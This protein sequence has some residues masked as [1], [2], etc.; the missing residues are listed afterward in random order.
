MFSMYS[1]AQENPCADGQKLMN[2]YRFEKALQ[3]LEI[4]GD[5]SL[6]NV[7]KKALCAFKLGRYNTARNLFNEVLKS[8][9]IHVQSLLNLGMLNFADNQFDASLLYFSKLCELDPDNSYYLKQAGIS[10]YRAGSISKAMDFY[11]SAISINPND[12]EAGS[13]LID[14]YLMLENFDQAKSLA[15]ELL[16]SDPKNVK[17][18]NKKAKICYKEKDYV[19]ALE[20]VKAALNLGDTSSYSIQ[21]AGIS[22]FHLKKYKES[23]M[24]F[25]I[26]ISNNEESETIN[27]YLG[28][29]YRESGN[30]QLGIEHLNRAIEMGVSTNL[31]HYYTQLAVT[32]EEKKNYTQAIKYYQIA[33]QHSK[34]KILL[35]HLARNYD[36]QYKDKKQAIKYYEKYLAE[37]DTVNASYME[38]SKYRIRDIKGALHF[39]ADTLN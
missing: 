19:N 12:M 9:S 37:N 24:L 6:E 25:N 1:S 20:S 8:D 30:L 27:Y 22:S 21:I 39:S 10:A 26:L 15:E 2:E 7:H 32:F 3:M 4:C 33:Y 17:I 14:I 28:L 5:N 29:A 23:V 34:E 16:K 35:Y 38:Y 36:H 18:L 31:S 11:T 13:N